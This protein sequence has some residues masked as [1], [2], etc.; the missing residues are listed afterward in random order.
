MTTNEE[1]IRELIERWARAVHQGD[2]ASV[3][4]DHAEDIV[5]FDVPPPQQGVRGIDAYRQ[6]W[7]PFF[8]WQ[9]QGASFEIESLDVTAGDDVAF[10]YALLRCGTPDDLAE[11]PDRRL[12]LTLGL[13][14]HDDR[15]V[16]THEHHS[17]ALDPAPDRDSASD[18]RELH[19][20]HE[21][22]FAATAAKDLDALMEPIATDVVSYEHEA[23]LRYVGEPAVREVC[24]AGLDASGDG[25]VSWEVPDQTLVVDG[26]LAV[27]WGLNR[28]RVTPPGAATVESWSRGTR[29][30]A[31]RDGGWR[32]V[33]QHLSYPFDPTTGA[34]RTDLL[35]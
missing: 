7:P 12:R 30:F 29:V 32:L 33:H 16:V 10:A 13:R 15:W 20:L 1:Q 27:S 26:D 5:M 35:P 34:A 22:W 21:R 11:A 24:R 31:R 2:L 4:A 18:E 25:A 6:T 19:A 23:P 3:L 17:F 28:V 14:R 8:R 9:A